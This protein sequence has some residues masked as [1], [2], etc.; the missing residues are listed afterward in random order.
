MDRETLE[1]YG[2]A[3]IGAVEGILK[4]YVRPEITAKRTWI[5]IGALV[6][7]HEVYCPPGELLSEGAD[8]AI[9]KYPVAVPV[10][11]AVLA[12]HVLNVFP[13]KVDPVHQGFQLIRRVF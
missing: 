12:G 6:A 13:E 10:L 4:Y 9:A 1:T 11:G 3:A 5:A 7:M 8:R 2:L